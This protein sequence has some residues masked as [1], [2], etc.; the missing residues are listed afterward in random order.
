MIVNVQHLVIENLSLKADS[1]WLISTGVTF[2]VQLSFKFRLLAPY[3]F[4]N[5]SK[6][7]SKKTPPRHPSFYFA[8]KDKSRKIKVPSSVPIFVALRNSRI[9]KQIRS[10]SPR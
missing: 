8:L 9:R 4:G 2:S 1:F 5:S 6:E 10:D 7:V 3:F